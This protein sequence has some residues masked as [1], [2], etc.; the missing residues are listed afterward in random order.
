MVQ[1]TQISSSS[2]ERYKRDIDR[3]LAKF[4]KREKEF[5]AQQ[6][7]ERAAELG[8]PVPSLRSREVSTRLSQWNDTLA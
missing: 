2:E 4:E 5:M 8:L 3:E 7:R 6:R 1:R